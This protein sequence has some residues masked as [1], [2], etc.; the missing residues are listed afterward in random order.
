[1][2]SQVLRTS[3]ALFP[4]DGSLETANVKF[5]LGTDRTV[6]AEQIAEQFSR[7]ESQV[8]NGVAASATTLD[9]NLTSKEITG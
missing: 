6:T 7:A 9:G 4:T 3:E 1:M 2:S 8:R 5:F